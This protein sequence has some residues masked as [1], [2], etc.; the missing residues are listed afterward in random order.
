ME[1]RNLRVPGKW[2]KIATSRATWATTGASSSPRRASEGFK[3]K[4]HEVKKH[5]IEHVHNQQR[6][7][8][9]IRQDFIF[10]CRETHFKVS[11]AC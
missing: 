8:K 1:R 5:H 4:G 7:N 3:S 6:N 2:S 9:N 10:L 11:P